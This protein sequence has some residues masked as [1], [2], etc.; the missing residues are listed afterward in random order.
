MLSST[1]WLSESGINCQ[2]LLCHSQYSS[3]RVKLTAKNTSM[4]QEHIQDREWGWSVIYVFSSH[5]LGCIG[6]AAQQT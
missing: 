5:L 4:S 1:T 6:V 2:A 3:S